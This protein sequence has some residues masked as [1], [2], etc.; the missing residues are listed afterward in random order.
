MA[1][2]VSTDLMTVLFRTAGSRRYG[3]S[4]DSFVLIGGSVPQLRP[5]FRAWPVRCGSAVTVGETR[6]RFSA[7]FSP[8]LPM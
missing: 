8:F 1:D 3:F 6:G 2:D 5:D 7:K 4:D